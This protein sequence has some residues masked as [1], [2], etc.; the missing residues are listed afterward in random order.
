MSD[1]NERTRPTSIRTA[2]TPDPLDRFLGRA[3]LGSHS[4]G[5]VLVFEGRVRDTNEGRPVARLGYEAY[6]D[7]ATR[8][9]DAICREAGDRFAVGAISAA[10]RVGELE[11]GDVSVVVGVAAPHRDA[12]Y[13]ASRWVIEEIKRRLPVWKHEHYSDGESAWVGAPE[14]VTARLPRDSRVG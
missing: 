9:L 8:E 13:A 10:H 4:D 5:A 2:I 3:P 14:A 12:C 1:R 11:L 7:M 6:V